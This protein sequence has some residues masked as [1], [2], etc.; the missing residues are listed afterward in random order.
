MSQL[1][2]IFD[3]DRHLN[4]KLFDLLAYIII[5]DQV[6]LRSVSYIQNR[7]DP[8]T[9]GPHVFFVRHCT[10]NPSCQNFLNV[11]FVDCWM[12]G[13]CTGCMNDFVCKNKQ[14]IISYIDNHK[15]CLR[16]FPRSMLSLDYL[17][18]PYPDPLL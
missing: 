4:K 6:C 16:Y 3:Y 5:Y 13:C 11:N 1:L 12:T 7:T 18:T 14:K 2:P 9:G 10:D 15:H 8:D 17:V